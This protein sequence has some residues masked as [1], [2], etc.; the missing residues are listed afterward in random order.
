[1]IA[2]AFRVRGADAILLN[3][4]AP[5]RTVSRCLARPAT[6]V[7]A[8]APHYGTL[9]Q[10]KA[11][12]YDE[13]ITAAVALDV[14]KNMLI[15]QLAVLIDPDADTPVRND[16]DCVCVTKTA[17]AVCSTGTT[18]HQDVPSLPTMQF[19]GVEWL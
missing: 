16:S 13:D 11:E 5:F 8:Y 14:D 18:S 3:A 2:T 19:S 12:V 6:R 4:L 7:A 9:T 1:L 15:E 10:R 17:V